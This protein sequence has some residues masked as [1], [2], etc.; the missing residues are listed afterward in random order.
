[1]IKLSKLCQRLFIPVTHNGSFFSYK[2]PRRVKQL[3]EMDKYEIANSYSK[4]DILGL[5]WLVGNIRSIFA[6]VDI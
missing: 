2:I 1:M 6:R 3:W 4:G 5:S